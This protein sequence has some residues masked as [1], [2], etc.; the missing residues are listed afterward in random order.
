MT[1]TLFRVAG[2]INENR[3]KVRVVISLTVKKEKT[4]LSR[5]CHSHLISQ[6]QTSAAFKM[7]LGQKYLDVA[8]QLRLIRWGKPKED[9]K[10]ALERGMPC[11][12]QWLGSETIPPPV[13]KK[14]KCHDLNLLAMGTG[15]ALP[16]RCGST[17]LA[18]VHTTHT[19][20][21]GI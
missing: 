5:D 20:E 6:H 15:L 8:D 11:R 21:T 2:W 3:R 1:D 13:C 12:I 17:T 4:R 7:L 16:R 9:W 14:S 18:P 10:V 19:P